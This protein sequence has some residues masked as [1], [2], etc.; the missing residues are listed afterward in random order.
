MAN[1]L[2]TTLRPM[3]ARSGALRAGIRYNS[4]NAAAIDSQAL[5]HYRQHPLAF[6]R[7]PLSEIY[8]EPTTH[9]VRA[10]EKTPAIRIRGATPTKNT[11]LHHITPFAVAKFCSFGEKGNLGKSVNYG[12]GK[13]EVR[14]LE[15][16]H[17]ELSIG[18]DPL[19][20]QSEFNEEVEAY[21]EWLNGFREKYID[22]LVEATDEYEVLKAAH[23]GK[24]EATRR[25]L[26]EDNVSKLVRQYVKEGVT[27]PHSDM[28]NVSEKIYFRSKSPN[29]TTYCDS[30]VEM[31]EKGFARRNIPLYDSE[32][33]VIPVKDASV[34]AGDVISMEL[35]LSCRIWKVAGRVG[36]SFRYNPRSVI[37]LRHTE[38]RG[39][40]EASSPFSNYA[41]EH[42]GTVYEQ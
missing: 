38:R 5:E 36:A 3:A 41:F 12:H 22:H 32:H 14:T 7:F 24:S 21:F 2:R 1:L 16:A 23:G 20:N 39:G 10:N 13:V 30:D 34:F 18:L 29:P 11:G 40:S 8:F 17:Q 19:A 42:G 27:V 9:F 15:E 4:D 28:L 25:A 33:Q 26:I 37:L 6:H 35:N 31:A